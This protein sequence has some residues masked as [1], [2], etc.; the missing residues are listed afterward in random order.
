MLMPPLD[1]AQSLITRPN[2]HI[3]PFAKA[4]LCPVASEGMGAGVAVINA[5]INN[6]WHSGVAAAAR[7]EAEPV[8]LA[9]FV[10]GA[11]MVEIERIQAR[12]PLAGDDGNVDG[13]GRGSAERGEEKAGKMHL[14]R[15]GWMRE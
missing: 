2:R 14:V 5:K 10:P 3:G 13:R 4:N 12:A 7:G 11:L 1:R 8:D 15:C 9:A 6:V